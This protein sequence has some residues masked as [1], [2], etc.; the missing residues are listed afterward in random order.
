M[1]FVLVDALEKNKYDDNFHTREISYDEENTYN[2]NEIK[3]RYKKYNLKICV[4]L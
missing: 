2:L 1:F 3:N 4:I